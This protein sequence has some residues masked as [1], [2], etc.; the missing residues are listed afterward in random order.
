MLTMGRPR[1]F[2]SLA[3]L[4]EHCYNSVKIFIIPVRKLM[5]GLLQDLRCAQG[6]AQTLLTM[7]P[8]RSPALS[9]AVIQ[10][11]QN[12][13]GRHRIER[14][15]TLFSGPPAICGAPGPNMSQVS[16]VTRF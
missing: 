11:I 3:L 15:C 13:M 4:P 6:K 2:C 1:S 7:E 12:T 5:G 14:N 8:L 10:S 9:W 16:L